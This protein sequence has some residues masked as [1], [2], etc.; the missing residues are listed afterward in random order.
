MSKARPLAAAVVVALLSVPLAVMILGA[1]HA[2]GK[3]APVG[4]EL[5][6]IEPTFAAFERA[7]ELVPL[8]RQFLNSLTV[9]A[10]A[11]P[12]SVACASLAGFAMT[13]M[14]RRWHAVAIGFTLVTL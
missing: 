14:G 10:I 11:V 5:V 2:P 13:R 6:R 4:L 8:G 1:L 7:F 12:L 3:P 9:V